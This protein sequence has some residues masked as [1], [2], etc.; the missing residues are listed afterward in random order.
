M[1]GE[2]FLKKIIKFIN[3]YERSYDKDDLLSVPKL[4]EYLGLTK[5]KTEKLLQIY[6][7]PAINDKGRTYAIK[8]EVAKW[9]EQNSNKYEGLRRGA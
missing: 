5:G 6:G 1:K 7:F 8:P 2:L 3:P 9:L 4:Q